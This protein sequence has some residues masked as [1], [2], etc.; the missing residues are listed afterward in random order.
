MIAV[1]GSDDD[2]FPGMCRRARNAVTLPVL[3]LPIHTPF[4]QP[5]WFFSLE[6]ASV[7]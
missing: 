4:G 7:T 1:T 3:A 5:G 6:S 2:A